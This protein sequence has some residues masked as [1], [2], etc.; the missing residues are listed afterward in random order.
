[1]FESELKGIFQKK[2]DRHYLVGLFFCC[3]KVRILLKSLILI[4]PQWL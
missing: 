1:M 2:D 3:G 4:S